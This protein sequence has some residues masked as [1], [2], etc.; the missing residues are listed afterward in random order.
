MKR[1]EPYDFSTHF[2]SPYSQSN[3]GVIQHFFA[4]I[5]Q[6]SEMIVCQVTFFQSYV[7]QGKMNYVFYI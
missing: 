4:N 1:V 5:D 2:S 6:E 3:I 7:E